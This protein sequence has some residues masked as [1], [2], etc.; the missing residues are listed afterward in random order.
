MTA[1]DHPENVLRYDRSFAA[2]P[3]KVFAV[4]TRP[5]LI[6]V[7]SAAAQGFRAGD[8]LVDLRPGGQ[9]SLTNRKDAIV[10][11]VGGTYHEVIADQR[12]CYSYHVAGTDFFSVISLDFA[13]TDLGTR[14][15][16]CQ[17]GFPSLAAF[18]DHRFGWPLALR[19]ITEGLV[20][21]LRAERAFARD[22]PLSGVAAD[23]Q[24]ARQRM[25][26]ERDAAG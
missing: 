10:E 20:L 24:A 13:A 7:W 25:E 1:A 19:V 5:E 21:A 8:V 18:E 2:T 22:R 16:F 11:Q 6:A 9:W 14:M 26:A 4:W 12:L 15:Q 3:A 23:L 17:T